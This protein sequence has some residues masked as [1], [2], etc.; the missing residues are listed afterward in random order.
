MKDRFHAYLQGAVGGQG[1]RRRG[2]DGAAARR[3]LRVA[4]ALFSPGCARENLK[5]EL[6]RK[7]VAGTDETI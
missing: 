3:A 1:S 4:G 2:S 6:I 7:V 5:A